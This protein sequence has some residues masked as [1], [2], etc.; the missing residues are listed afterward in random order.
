MIRDLWPL[1]HCQAKLTIVKGHTICLDLGVC[2]DIGNN[3]L[4]RVTLSQSCY[5]P[6]VFQDSFITLRFDRILHRISCIPPSAFRPGEALGIILFWRRCYNCVRCGFNLLLI[7]EGFGMCGNLTEIWFG[8][9]FFFI[10]FILLLYFFHSYY[11]YIF[12][13][14]Y[15]IIIFFI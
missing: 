14:I 8:M 9:F 13:F 15:I 12:H 7:V 11:N 4:I 6:W 2:P 3:A 10:L 5:L 1:S